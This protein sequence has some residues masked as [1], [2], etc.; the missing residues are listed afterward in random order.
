MNNVKLGATEKLSGKCS[1]LPWIVD[2]GASHHMTGQLE[3]LTNVRNILEY[4]V[5]LP[6][7][8]EIVATKEGTVVLNDKLRLTNVL[9]V[10]SLHCNA[11][12]VSQLLKDS[13]CMIQ[14]TDKFLLI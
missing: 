11:V 1:L 6:N 14:F 2:M 8:A 12:S 3:C 7:G 9:Y 4:S 10:P 13:D 5:G